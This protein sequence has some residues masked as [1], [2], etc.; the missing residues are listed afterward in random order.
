[1]GH[2]GAFAQGTRFSRKYAIGCLFDV[3]TLSGWPCLLHATNLRLQAAINCRL[4]KQEHE[5]RFS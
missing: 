4:T 1:M 2:G 5:I 3:G